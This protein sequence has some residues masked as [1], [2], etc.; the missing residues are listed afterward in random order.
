M[1]LQS[2]K[3]KNLSQESD[4]EK[5][6]KARTVLF[7]TVGYLFLIIIILAYIYAIFVITAN[8]TEKYDYSIIREWLYGFL[9]SLFLDFF[10]IQIGKVFIHLGI[11]KTLRN[12]SKKK[13][14]CI[15]RKHLPKMLSPV[16]FDFQKVFFRVIFI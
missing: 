6:L 7:N 12:E 8:N 5:K 9:L 10:G 3:A 14:L 15:P 13:F 4:K 16:I 1:A 11:L 2:K